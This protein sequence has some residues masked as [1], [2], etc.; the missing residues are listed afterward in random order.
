MNTIRGTINDLLDVPAITDVA[1]G[2]VW[3]GHVTDLDAEQPFCIFHMEGGAEEWAMGDGGLETEV[4][5]VKG[6]GE[7]AGKVEDVDTIA[8]GLMH[9]AVGQFCRR[10]GPIEYREVNGGTTTYYRGSRYQIRKDRQA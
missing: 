2:G 3:F 4:W 1:T 10:L 9:D 5:V 7:D 8:Q 6:A